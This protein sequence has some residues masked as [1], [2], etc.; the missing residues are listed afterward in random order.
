VAADA[1]A[2]PFVHDHHCHLGNRGARLADVASHPDPAPGAVERGDRLVVVVVGLGETAQ[3]GRGQPALATQ[4]AQPAA[5]AA[6]PFEAVHEQRLVRA[7]HR[8]QRTSAR[9][10]ACAA[11]ERL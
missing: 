5:L 7:A 10:L 11:E 8:T 2:V 6:Q 4:E 1:A 9:A 3:V